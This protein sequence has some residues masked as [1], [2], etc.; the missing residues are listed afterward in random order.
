MSP[1]NYK[2]T[3]VSRDEARKL[4]ARI[5][6]EYPASIFWTAHCMD[7][8]I[9]RELS[10]DDVFNV[11]NSPHARVLIEG[12]LSAKGVYSYRVETNKMFVVVSFSS[13]ASK[14]SIVTVA[15]K[16]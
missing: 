4:V 9:D 13:D 14:M 1:Q 11:L 2:T 6:Q 12:E 8:L 5:L 3:R 7:R 16:D 15:R 10:T